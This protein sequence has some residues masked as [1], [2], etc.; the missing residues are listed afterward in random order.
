MTQDTIL[1]LM[2]II[3]LLPLL[4]FVINI[5]WG[6]KLGKASS[7]I[8]SSI[9]GIDL[10]LA[11]IVFVGKYFSFPNVDYLQLKFEWFNLGHIKI[12]VGVGGDNVAVVMLMVVTIISF[13]VHLF[14]T[15]YMAGDVRF[16]RYY[17]Y[18]GL[19]T[20]SMLGIVIANNFLFMYIF[21]ELVGISSYL[22]IGFW[23]K[24]IQQPMQVRRHF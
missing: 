9:L 19:F 17:A 22:L 11:I 18:L 10:I 4:S 5:F 6:K 21:W 15:E 2:I 20:F 1:R 13:L 24:K 7:I 23:Y 14:S 3:L 12:M 8:G 16:S